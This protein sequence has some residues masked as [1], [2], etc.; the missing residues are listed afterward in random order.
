MKKG[1]I[2]K[3]KDDEGEDDEGEAEGEDNNNF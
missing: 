1:I 3:K 2:A